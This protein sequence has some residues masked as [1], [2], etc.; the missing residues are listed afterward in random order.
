MKTRII[1]GCVLIPLTMAAILL[2]GWVFDVICIAAIALALHEMTG[3]LIK[4][5]HQVVRWP[6]WA[7]TVLSVP[8]FL[9][10]KGVAL[11]PI[12]FGT[13]LIITMYVLFHGEPHLED[14][15]VSVMPLL[16]VTL[17]GMCLL[18]QN[19]AV[20]ELWRVP[21]ICLS[22]LVP[23][24]GDTAAYFIGVRFGSKKLIPKVSPNKTVEGAAA[25]LM[26]SVLCALAIWGIACAT[27][28]DKVLMPPM[29]HFAVIGLLGGVVGQVGDLY[30]S[31]IKRHCGIKDYSNLIP[32]HGG[33][34]DRMDSILFVSALVYIYQQI[35]LK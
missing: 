29:W 28:G 2:G 23:V 34:M 7:A 35:L 19:H 15:L 17:P 5:G 20:N 10:Y 13:I 31:L 24:A 22:L 14:I 27:M 18:S 1:T 25:G 26:G 21:L 12:L 30:A 16:S 6:V 9:V 11:L 3:A 4:K 8:A 32:G 33:V